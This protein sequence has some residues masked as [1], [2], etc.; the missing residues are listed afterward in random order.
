MS[1]AYKE[2]AKMWLRRSID[3]RRASIYLTFSAVHMFFCSAFLLL[4]VLADFLF[5]GTWFWPPAVVAMG[6]FFLSFLNHLI[7]YGFFYSLKI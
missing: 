3:F 6:F 4:A 1:K 5:N 7:R 2:I